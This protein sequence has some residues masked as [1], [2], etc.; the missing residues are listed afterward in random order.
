MQSNPYLP[1]IYSVNLYKI[2]KL[3]EPYYFYRLRMEKLYPLTTLS[4][5]ELQQIVDKAF[6]ITSRP[7]AGS[8]M[9]L[10]KVKMKDE[11]TPTTIRNGK[12]TPTGK[13]DEYNKTEL[14][15]MVIDTIDGAL[16]YRNYSGNIINHSIDN[17]VNIKDPKLKHAIFIIKNLLRAGGVINDIHGDNLMFR[18]TSIGPQL[19]IL[20]PLSNYA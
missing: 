10:G 1:K 9:D 6:Y 20:D 12:E 8:K 19:V 2:Y 11:H 17:T 16:E 4:T 7:S 15:T 13:T 18:R 14:L 3:N 5:P